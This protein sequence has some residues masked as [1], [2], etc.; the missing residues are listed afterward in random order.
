MD[1]PGV[2]GPD[3]RKE[4]GIVEHISKA[5]MVYEIFGACGSPELVAAYMAKS[6]D[7]EYQSWNRVFADVEY[8]SWF[9]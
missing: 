1:G 2:A 8:E 6:G 9:K 3:R 4:G 5:M 7:V